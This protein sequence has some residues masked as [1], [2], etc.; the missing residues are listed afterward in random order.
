M[1]WHDCPVLVVDDDQAI[2]ELVTDVLE[3]EGYPVRAAIDGEEAL[4]AI[5]AI[6]AADPDCPRVVLLDMKMPGLDGWG[7]ARHLRE[8]G[9][10]ISIVVMT[11]ARDARQWARE[12]GADAYLAK[13]F[14]LDDLLAA[15]TR[16]AGHPG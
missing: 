9:L 5:E 15:V 14:Q 16:F 1:E 7:F 4:L 13:P 11:A 6:R 12:I 8:R 3:D 2:R 10:P